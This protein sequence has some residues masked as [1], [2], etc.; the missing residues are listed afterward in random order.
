MSRISPFSIRHVRSKYC[1]L[2]KR[3]TLVLGLATLLLV[4][5]DCATVPITGRSQLLLVS[6]DEVAALT[7]DSVTQLQNYLRR[8][9]K[10]LSASESPEAPAVIARVNNVSSRLLQISGLQSRFQWQVM[11]VKAGE[12]NAMVTPNGKIMVFTGI[13]PIA[14][15]E[16]G[17]AAVIGHEIGHLMARHT[18]ERLSRL[19][20]G[21]AALQGIRQATAR[22]KYRS[23]IATAAGLGMQYGLHL[24]FDRE[25]ESEADRI[26]QIL[27]AKA[28]YDPSEAIE[29][30][31]RMDERGG[32]QPWEFLSGHPSHA[33]R[34]AQLKEWLPEAMV[35]YAD[36]GRAL[37]SD[38]L[39][40][41]TRPPADSQSRVFPIALRPS[42]APGYWWRFERSNETKP[43]LR[44]FDRMEHCAVGECIVIVDDEGTVS[45]VND[46]YE[47]V[48]ETRTPKGI[49]RMTPPMKILSWPLSVGSSWSQPIRM[50][51]PEGVLNV[52]MR[53]EVVG[54][55]SIDTR[56]GSFMAFK[57][58][59][60][61]NGNKFMEYWYSPDRKSVV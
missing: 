3:A 36:G 54:Y 43:T 42:L 44:R 24:P 35:Y 12:A 21:N 20:L 57:M 10:I 5:T 40:A 59:A 28:G 39:I 4:S 32:F 33:T 50:E 11:V 8:S 23:V 1:S 16:A 9:G 30:W 52:T 25:Q 19:M 49:S 60:S 26:G 17:L 38:L 27:M 2:L 46:T 61:A 14:K 34:Q 47:A 58:V 56:A 41:H 45:Y 13:L 55:E 31:K 7:D 53:M 18:A 22:S 6:D 37:P 15:S 48:V 51:R 29:V